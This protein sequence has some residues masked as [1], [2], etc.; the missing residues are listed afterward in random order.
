M[1]RRGERPP[2]GR[3]G[4]RG[5]R[6]GAGALALF[7]CALALGLGCAPRTPP[8]P[9]PAAASLPGA[10]QARASGAVRV[11][12]VRIPGRV[13][14]DYLV[15]PDGA[16]TIT[17]LVATAPDVD[18]VSRFLFFET[19]RLRFR[20]TRF[21]N[22]E[23]IRGALDAGGRMVF[24]PGAA[25]L[26]GLSFDERA[27]DRT[28]PGRARRITAQND[29]ALTA[30][31]DPA[32]NRFTFSGRFRATVDGEDL[33]LRITAE[34]GYVN[35]PPEARLGVGGPDL[36]EDLIQGGCPPLVG[37]NPPAAEANDPGGLAIVLQSLSADPDGRWSRAGL[38]REQWSHS[39]GGP[40]RLLG[41]GRRIGPVVFGFGVEHRLELTVTDVVGAR[42]RT[43]CRFRVVDTTPPAVAAPP[44]IEVP[45]SLPGGAT[46]ATSPALRAWLAAATAVDAVDP[47]PLPLPPQVGGRDVTPETLFPLD[48]GGPAARAAT[49]VAFRFRDR[50][51]L[52]GGERSTARVVVPAGDPSPC[53]AGAGGAP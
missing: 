30:E 40:Y 23:P 48:R 24:P 34:G 37:V 22:E 51:G 12:G 36:P 28:C 17:S 13:A 26:A 4:D 49:R 45:C 20:C 50:A 41:E 19:E 6:P 2:A 35:R 43:A 42:G 27:P 38:A 5:E 46:P 52:L 10:Y 33:D 9:G 25:K 3:R 47:Q 14:L 18:V 8:A 53:G 29:R 31:P 39:D 15:F 11:D 1:S 16:V 21:A 7:G 44:P 32:G